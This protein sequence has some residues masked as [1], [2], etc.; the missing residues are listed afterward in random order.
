LVAPSSCCGHHIWWHFVVSVQSE[1]HLALGA[2]WLF[3]HDLHEEEIS[4]ILVKG[5]CS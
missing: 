3:E 2:D 5:M 1:L 4:W